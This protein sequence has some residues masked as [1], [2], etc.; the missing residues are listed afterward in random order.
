LHALETDCGPSIRVYF[1][2][3]GCS[4][5][6]DGHRSSCLELDPAFP[7]NALPQETHQQYNAASFLPDTPD[8]LPSDPMTLFQDWFQQASR[9]GVKEPEAVALSTV[10]LSG[11]QPTPSTRFV[12]VKRVDERGLV[13]FTNYA[14][15]KAQE[16]DACPTA[17]MA[18]YWQDLSLSV[19]FVGNVEKV[20]HDESLEY[21]LSRP[22]GSRVGAW[23]SPQSQPIPGRAALD[24]AVEAT[25]RRFEVEPGSATRDAV[26]ADEGKLQ[27]LPPHWGGYR[28]RPTEVEFWAGR[29]NR[30]HDR[31]RYL[32]AEDGKWQIDRL[33]P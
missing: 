6:E 2:Q 8:A 3:D 22:L 26:P 11:P 15:R 12:L 1:A 20:A 13:W 17:S 31:Y 18:F 27:E 30:L 19:R 29:K 16:I 32:K 14:S 25:E 33:G 28:L 10:S 7:S 5:Q 24:E 9:A 4:A 21:F 23:A